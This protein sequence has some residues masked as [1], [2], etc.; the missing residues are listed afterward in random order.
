MLSAPSILE[1]VLKF[2]ALTMYLQKTEITLLPGSISITWQLTLSLKDCSRPPCRLKFSKS[3][4]R[5]AYRSNAN[6]VPDPLRQWQERRQKKTRLQLWSVTRY[7]GQDKSALLR[8]ERIVSQLRGVTGPINES[9]PVLL[10][11]SS[12]CHRSVVSPQPS[13]MHVSRSR[14]GCCLPISTTCQAWRLS[15]DS[16]NIQVQLLV[17]AQRCL[18]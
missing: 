4:Q 7:D 1:K 3:T 9:R 5:P 11:K 17:L 13:L 10:G 18:K 2:T 12:A 14:W 8:G 6:T 16:F 15:E